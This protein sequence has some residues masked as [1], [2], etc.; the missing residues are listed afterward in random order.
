MKKTALIIFSFIL[1]AAG[2]SVL[3]ACSIKSPS[4]KQAPQAVNEIQK[5]NSATTTENNVVATSTAET[6]PEINGNCPN[7][8]WWCESASKCETSDEGCVHSTLR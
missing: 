3:S 8:F 4:A 7:G 2:L 5:E 1:L 6:G